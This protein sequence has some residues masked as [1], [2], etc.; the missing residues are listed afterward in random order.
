M[1]R[2]LEWECIARECLAFFSLTQARPLV[3]WFATSLRNN[4][5][6]PT[7]VDPVAPF[8]ELR[9]S[10]RFYS[11][12]NKLG[13]GLALVSPVAGPQDLAEALQ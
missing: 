1:P 6:V 11:S 2:S 4:P 13:F 10:V 8:P 7:L 9:A 12:L 3:R 5:R